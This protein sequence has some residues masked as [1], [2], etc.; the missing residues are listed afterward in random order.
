MKTAAKPPIVAILVLVKQHIFVSMVYD[1]RGIHVKQTMNVVVGVAMIK[2]HLRSVI[3]LGCANKAV[4]KIL[5]VHL[6]YVR[7]KIHKKFHVVVKTTVP[8]LF[9]V[10]EIKQKMIRVIK[11]RSA[12]KDLN[13]LLTTVFEKKIKQRIMRVNQK[14]KNG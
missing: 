12:L 2:K 10:M 9:Y 6:A 11:M 13:V 4:F 1:K 3:Y 7:A 8:I 5:I 14:L